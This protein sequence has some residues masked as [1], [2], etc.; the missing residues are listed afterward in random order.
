MGEIGY[1]VALSQYHYTFSMYRFRQIKEQEARRR[2]EREE[3]RR[4]VEEAAKES[5]SEDDCSK[6][7]PEKVNGS[8]ANQEER[9]EVL[10]PGTNNGGIAHN[11]SL[12]TDDSP[13]NAQK[14]YN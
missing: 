14:V 11:S 1:L 8:H 4:K 9:I 12:G 10:Y 7:S 13:E 6:V 5:Y 2:Q 3:D